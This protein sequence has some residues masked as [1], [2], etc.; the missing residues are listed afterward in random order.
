MLRLFALSRAARFASWLT[1]PLRGLLAEDRAV[2]VIALA[3]GL[4]ELLTLFW[5]LPGS[6]G[7]DNDGIAPRDLFGGIADNLLPGHTHQYPLL[8]YLVLGVA[9]LPIL[10]AAVLSGPLDAAA[11]RERIL[12]VPCM[13]GISL[14]AKLL[15]AALACLALVV[16]A[17][18][19]RRT[20]GTRAGRI[21]ALFAAVNLTFAFYGRVSNLDVPYLAVTLLALDRLLDIVERG[22]RRS[23][24]GFG[25]L[26]ATA[27]ATKDQAYAA[28]V[29][30]APLYLVVFPLVQ[31]ERFAPD[32]F[33]RLLR[34]GGFALLAYAVASGALFNPTG[35]VKR[36][37]VLRG[38]ASQDWRIYSKDPAG[39][40][41]NLQDGF[42]L[43]PSAF[44][45]APVLLLVWLFA[46]VAVARP[47]GDSALTQRLPRALPL[48]AGVSS[49]LFF[50]LAVGRSEH[51]FLL[52][53]G[54]LLSAYGGVAGD[55]LLG[56]ATSTKM[57]GAV[58]LALGAAL[59][60]AG[61][62]SFAT[63]LTQFGDAR[64]QARALLA[65]VPAGTL[66]ETYGLLVYQ[67]HFDVSDDSPYRVERIG[68]EAPE[69]RNPLVGAREVKAAIADVETRRPDVIL[70]PG[71]FSNSYRTRTP[72]AARPLP[73]VVTERRK[74][75]DTLEF[76]Q[77]ATTGTLPHYRLVARLDPELPRIA[78]ALGLRPVGLHA[79]IGMPVW[80]LVR[81]DGRA[82]D[83]ETP[84]GLSRTARSESR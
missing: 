2:A 12:S 26:A 27:V 51:R 30:V 78:T 7:W 73:A 15:C 82:R 71:G 62:R 25:V 59:G 10:L 48:V 41:A 37:A 1:G 35:F 46:V 47:P 18:V 72:D 68:P 79:T 53:L 84:P 50:S 40:L 43:Q 9:C 42:A 33:R 8:P 28:F 29:L 32:H 13:T 31:R 38:P 69:R 64:N 34:A 81:R 39:L 54:F 44:W 22:T 36:L 52:P 17:R 4:S 70:I 58:T 16:L 6:H 45:P 66:V 19:V 65:R 63:Q 11:V 55:V 80:V 75:T 24:L 14:V 49:F 5:D 56:L 21:A 74:D 61:L 3:F 60:W 83:L 67:P 20:H 23:Y 76:V 77:R 57:Q